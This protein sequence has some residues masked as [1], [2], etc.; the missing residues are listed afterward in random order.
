[1]IFKNIK[2]KTL[3]GLWC[4]LYFYPY[5]TIFHVILKQWGLHNGNNRLTS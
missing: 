5:L 2:E 1:M 3:T 4:D